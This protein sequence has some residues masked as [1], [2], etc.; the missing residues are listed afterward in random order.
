VTLVM[1]KYG[2][3]IKESDDASLIAYVEARL[4]ALVP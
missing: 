2:A 4:A 1:G 3:P